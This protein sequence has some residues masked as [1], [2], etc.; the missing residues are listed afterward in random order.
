MITLEGVSKQ[1][2]YGARVLGSLDMTINDGQIVALLGDESSGKTTFLKVVASVTDCEGKVLFDGQPLAKKPDDVIMV[3]DDLAMFENRSCYYNLAYPLIIRGYD[4]NEIKRIAGDC[5]ER[6]GVVAILRDKVRKTSLIDRKRLAVARLFSRP[7]KVV[8][9]D[10]ITRGLDKE[11]AAEL[12]SEVAPV[13]QDMAKEGRIVVFATRDKDEAMSIADTIV[14]MHY[15]EVKQIGTP[16]RIL[17]NP[18][19]I[20]AAQAFDEDYRFEKARLDEKNGKL[21]ATTLDGYDIDLCH[22]YGKIVDEYVGKDVFVGWASDCYDVDGDR[23]ESV[24]SYM[25][26]QNGYEM[27]VQSG[28]V[29]CDKKL[30]EVGT[31]P[32]KNAAKV[33]DFASENSIIK[34][35][36]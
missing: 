34:D 17:E 33:F 14:V 29:R 25:R 2:L 16:D 8:L 31:L 11:E 4:K 26:T 23:K 18:S 6:A 7:S 9:V 5:A 27:H 10:D 12:W 1:Y 36:I 32:L 13:L 3:F 28:V 22:L 15:G 20:W 30:D 21:V 24:Q 19:N 35:E